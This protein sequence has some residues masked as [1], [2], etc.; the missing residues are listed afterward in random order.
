MH[1]FETWQFSCM[2]KEEHKYFIAMCEN[3]PYNILDN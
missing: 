2:C 1:P 3:C